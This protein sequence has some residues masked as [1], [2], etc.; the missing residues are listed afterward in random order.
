MLL[1]VKHQSRGLQSGSSRNKGPLSFKTVS[2]KDYE[3]ANSK[4]GQQFMTGVYSRMSK[5]KQ[6]LTAEE[7]RCFTSVPRMR[8]ANPISALT[9]NASR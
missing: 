7:P 6:Q 2:E 5:L 1:K 9:M 4:L 8:M 3:D